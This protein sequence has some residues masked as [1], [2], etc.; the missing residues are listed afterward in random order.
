MASGAQELVGLEAFSREGDKIG[1]I[2]DVICDPG[3]LSDCV[4]IKHSLRRDLVVPADVVE[5]RD[6]GVTVPFGTSYLHV[7]PRIATKGEL[8]GEDRARLERFYHP[9]A[10]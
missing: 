5:R 7:A 9:A 4:V 6:E 8:S 1:R 3:A 10:V 2:K